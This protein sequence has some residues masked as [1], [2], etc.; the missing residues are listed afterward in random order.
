MWC[1]GHVVPE[2]DERPRESHM[3]QKKQELSPHKRL[4]GLGLHGG[5]IVWP[6]VQAA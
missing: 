1:L 4:G 5:A 6:S 3:D 2:E